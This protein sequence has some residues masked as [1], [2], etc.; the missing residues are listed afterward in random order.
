MSRPNPGV[1]AI[2]VR[3]NKVVG[4]GWTQVGGRPHAE[5][6]ALTLAGAKA[7]GATAY[8]TLE[9]CAHKSERGPSCAQS[10]IE[11]GVARVV[12]GVTDP[13]PRTAGDGAAMLREAGIVV[14]NADHAPSRASLAGYLARQN[15]SRPH[16]TLKLAL[17]LDGKIALADGTSQWITGE[18]ARAHT[19]AER[20]KADAILVGGG[21]W[22]ADKPSLDVRLPGLEDRSP[23]KVLL[24]RGVP[25]DG[26]KVINDPT[27]I[28]KL[29]D[30]LHL[31][32]E[33]GAGAA[34]SF[35]TA[36]LV[37]RLLIYRAPILLGGDAHPAI[38]DLGLTDLAASH[39][40]W[41]LAE[42]CQLGSDRCEAYDRVRSE[43]A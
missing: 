4:Q 33:G 39:G 37:D 9:P 11:A 8:V 6:E 26:V 12:I 25:P 32:V 22:R 35:L 27:D 16:V 40:Q 17:S 30:V 34:A 3:D 28:A 41:Q 19:H 43:E 29:D 14:E 18:E 7:E 36:D 23:K 1:A 38:G 24:S 31:F 10:L 5:A 15:H 20:A 42:Q 13:D 21:T 2:L